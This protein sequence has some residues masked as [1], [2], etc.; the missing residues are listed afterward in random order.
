M[1]GSVQKPVLQDWKTDY[2]MP[3]KYL[4]FGSPFISRKQIYNE[5]NINHFSNNTVYPAVHLNK[6]TDKCR[7]PVPLLASGKS[8]DAAASYGASDRCSGF[9]RN[10]RPALKTLNVVTCQMKLIVIRYDSVS[11]F[12]MRGLYCIFF[13][14]DA[15]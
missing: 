3:V 12:R 8:I 11:F 5:M 6:R 2:Y 10:M 15:G 1:N 14:T 9:I 13:V 7:A 4:P